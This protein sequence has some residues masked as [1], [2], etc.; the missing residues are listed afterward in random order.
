[1]RTVFTEKD[2]AIKS[3]DPDELVEMG[4]EYQGSISGLRNELTKMIERSKKE[5]LQKGKKSSFIAGFDKGRHE[6]F[7]MIK[8]LYDP[9][10]ML[11]MLYELISETAMSENEEE[12]IAIR[13]EQIHSYLD[14]I[15]KNESIDLE[16]E[17]SE[18]L[19]LTDQYLK[20]LKMYGEDDDFSDEELERLS[21]HFDVTFF[22]PLSKII[23]T[24]LS[25]IKSG[26]LSIPV[27][28]GDFPLPDEG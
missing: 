17:K 12:E 15:A 2:L 19:N 27:D 20:M 8:D 21:S 22:E 1:M 6:Y 28:T 3:K 4:L 18:M 7:L 14:E 24:I 10:Y 26:N 25:R 5:G 11:L 9:H 13:L 23:E 16:S